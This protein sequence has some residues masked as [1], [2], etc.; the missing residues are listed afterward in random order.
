M[1]KMDSCFAFDFTD[2]DQEIIL[3]VIARFF[4]KRF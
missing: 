1:V 2:A 4:S 3:T